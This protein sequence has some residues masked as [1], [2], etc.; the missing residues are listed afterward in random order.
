MKPHGNSKQKTAPVYRRVA[1]S[2]LQRM[3]NMANSSR[4]STKSVIKNFI[5]E[6]GGIENIHAQ[7]IPRNEQQ[8][9]NLKRKMKDDDTDEINEILHEFDVQRDNF[10]R[11]IDIRPDFIVVLA[12][13]QQL[14]DLNRFCTRHPCSILGIDHTFHFGEF[15]VTVT[16]YRNPMLQDITPEKE[17]RNMKAMGTDGEVALANAS[18]MAFESAT[19][20][21]CFNHI[22]RN[23]KNK[24]QEIGVSK[25]NKKIVIS[26]IFGSL[27]DT[28]L[29]YA[30]LVDCLTNIEFDQKL[31]TL[32]EKWDTLSPNFYMWFK[33]H[34]ADNFKS[35]VI[36]SVRNVAGLSRSECYTTNDNESMNSALQKAKESCS[37]IYTPLEV[38]NGLS[39]SPDSCG[40]TDVQE[41]IIKDIWEKAERLLQK[42]FSIVF[43]PEYPDA[44]RVSS[45]SNPKTCHFVEICRK[46]GNIKC[47]CHL[48]KLHKICHHVLAVA[49]NAGVS[50][51][52]LQWRQKKKTTP[53]L[54]LAVNTTLPKS[55]GRKP[56]EKRGWAKKK[57]TC[58][59]PSDL[60]VI[61]PF[62]VDTENNYI[63]RFLKNT[64]IMVCYGCGKRFRSSTA[65]VPNPPFDIVLAKNRSIGIMSTNL[66][67]LNC[68]SGGNLSITILTHSVF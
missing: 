54:S 43:I 59:K 40:I 62:Q 18:L 29:R 61:E 35:H 26:D 4:Y 28:A 63:F 12:S 2:S 16:T 68:H 21:R 65:E 38:T 10:I 17:L 32:Q 22:Q 57:A 30:G 47:E 3:T 8:I 14:K 5:E 39:S 60:S 36:Q 33:R 67:S 11:K 52:Y 42:E 56:N 31:E 13:D 25:E 50:D 64:R 66:A 23:I 44:R 51:D 6:E 41:N 45:L 37:R 34:Y 53:S 48:N 55:A 24:L 58:T 15:D 27:A 20:L 46:T 7:D 19:Q 9:R 49:E 1:P